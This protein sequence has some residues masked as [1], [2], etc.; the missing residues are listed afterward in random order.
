MP[1]IQIIKLTKEGECMEQ[2]NIMEECSQRGFFARNGLCGACRKPFESCV[3]MT[4]HF[5]ENPEGAVKRDGLLV[6][7]P[8]FT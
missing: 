8:N 4:S 1:E 2:E 7:C 5:Y 3:R 6:E